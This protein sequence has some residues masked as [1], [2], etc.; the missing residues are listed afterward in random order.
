MW[1]L[2]I[3][4]LFFAVA[5]IQ[6]LF[7]PGALSQ[8]NCPLPG[9]SEVETLLLSTLI[10]NLGEGGNIQIELISHSFS[11]LAVQSRDRFAELSVVATYRLVGTTTSPPRTAQFELRCTSGSWHTEGGLDPNPPE[12]AF[13]MTRRDCIGCTGQQGPVEVYDGVTNCICKFYIYMEYK[14]IK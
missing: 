7:L 1:T 8:N 13:T 9:T 2:R 3:Y 4:S 6:L 14:L 5:V 10:A 11:C 12:G